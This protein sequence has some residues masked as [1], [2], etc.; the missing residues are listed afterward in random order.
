MAR[1]GGVEEDELKGDL[2]E[3]D[4]TCGLPTLD[5]GERPK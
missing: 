2:E 1:G 5:I 3:C 4:E